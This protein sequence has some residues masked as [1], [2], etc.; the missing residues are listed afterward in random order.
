MNVE[1][2]PTE[3]I[4]S[5]FG[6]EDD[7]FP[8]EWNLSEYIPAGVL[9]VSHIFVQMR[10]YDDSW[11]NE[12][13]GQSVVEFP[14]E[15]SF[16]NDTGIL[17]FPLSELTDPIGSIAFVRFRRLTPKT[18][19]R[20]PATIGYRVSEKSLRTNANQ[21]LFVAVEE[22]ARAGLDPSRVL[23]DARTM[24]SPFAQLSQNQYGADADYSNKVWSFSFQGGYL[25][26]AHVRAQALVDGAWVL[27]EIAEE[28]AYSDEPFRFIGDTALYLDLQTLGTV[29]GLVIFRHTPR[30][31][32]VSSPQDSDT[33]RA[34]AL[35]PS[36]V[37]G[38]MVAVELG[39][40]ASL[41]RRD[42]DRWYN[43][44]TNEWV[45]PP[46]GGGWGTQPGGWPTPTNLD[47]GPPAPKPRHPGPQVPAPEVAGDPGA[48]VVGLTDHVRIGFWLTAGAIFEEV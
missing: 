25:D 12:G 33:V 1:V 38:Y 24:V 18:L 34:S 48:Y 17:T 22:A 43:P 3:I 46:D 21:G 37:Q 4:F 41:G 29:E 13:L 14:F 40:A 26:R 28:D 32:L 42:V 7:S 30:D 36:A 45:Q 11:D 27:L 23:M 8:T 6:S 20:D 9:D 44:E 2:L 15:V 31:E 39:E 10:G 19:V 35:Y 47:G 5:A 16:D